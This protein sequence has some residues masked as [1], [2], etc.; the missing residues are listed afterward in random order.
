MNCKIGKQYQIYY[1]TPQILS[2]KQKVKR[3]N[4]IDYRGEGLLCLAG[5]Y[6][7]VATAQRNASS[8]VNTVKNKSEFY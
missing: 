2:L 1:T 5:F 7:V 6:Q 8:E 3:E 4:L